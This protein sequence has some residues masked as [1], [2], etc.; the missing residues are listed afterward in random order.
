MFRDFEKVADGSG[1]IGLSEGSVEFGNV[2][3]E[4]FH[5]TPLKVCVDYLC[6]LTHYF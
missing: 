6:N 2:E 4:G 5:G 3:R 1:N